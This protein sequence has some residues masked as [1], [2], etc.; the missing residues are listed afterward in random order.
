MSLTWDELPEVLNP[1]QVASVLHVS[2]STVRSMAASGEIPAR[3]VGA[4][5][6]F[7]RESIRRWLAVD[8]VAADADPTPPHGIDRP[9]LRSA[10]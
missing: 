6:R 10:S 8:P 3:K 5:W 4:Q 2:A 9:N 1:V 7:G